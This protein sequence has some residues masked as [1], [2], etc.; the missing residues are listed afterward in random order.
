[1]YP[2]NGTEQRMPRVPTGFWSMHCTCASFSRS[3]VGSLCTVL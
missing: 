3:L 2:H 1:M